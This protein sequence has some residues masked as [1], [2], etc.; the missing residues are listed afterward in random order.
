MPPVL[1][2][3]LEQLFGRAAEPPSR[4]LDFVEVFAGDAAVSH[5][6]EHLGYVGLQLDVRHDKSHDVLTPVGFMV[7][8]KA[9]MKIRR[10]GLIWAA[11]PCST[12]IWMSRF[13]SGRQEDVHGNPRS[14]YVVSQNALVC[15]LLSILHLCAQREVWIILEQPASSVM[16]QFPPM[17][18]FAE[19]HNVATAKL[20]L[21][22]Y[23]AATRKDTI[24]WWAAPYL[25]ELVRILS[26]HDRERLQNERVKTTAVYTDS[27][28]MKRCHGVA[29]LKGTHTYPVLFGTSHALCFHRAQHASMPVTP[30][31]PAAPASAAAPSASVPEPRPRAPAEPE[32]EELWFLEDIRRWDSEFWHTNAHAKGQLRLKRART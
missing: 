17:K 24:L 32:D 26:P 13:S 25:A 10:H 8:L 6:L 23:G 19:M 18:R 28:G 31:A 21:G 9:A 2:P 29:A 22:A 5:G 1:Q 4:P 7:L 20:Q 30:A 14:P 3:I 15:R 16:F 27:V 12:W 11:P